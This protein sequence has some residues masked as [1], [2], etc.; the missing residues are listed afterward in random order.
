MMIELSAVVG[1]ETH[2]FRLDTM[3][4]YYVQCVPF[5]LRVKT[6]VFSMSWQM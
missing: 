4:V 2:V 6:I 1:G 3:V 5:K